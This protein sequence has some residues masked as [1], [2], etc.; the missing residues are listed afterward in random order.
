MRSVF[1]QT[2]ERFTVL[3][4]CHDRP[5]FA[6][7]FDSRLQVMEADFEAPHPGGFC[8]AEG[9]RD[10]WEKLLDGLIATPALAPTYV[11]VRDCDDFI[12]RR[13]VAYCLRADDPNGYSLRTGYLHRTGS[14]WLTY[15]PAFWRN[16]GSS[17]VLRADRLRFPQSKGQAERDACLFMTHGHTV[18]RQAMVDRGWPLADIPFPSGVYS[19]SHGDNVTDTRKTPWAKLLRRSEC[20]DGLRELGLIRPLTRCIREEFSLPEAG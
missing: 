11:M 5:G 18:I 3:L 14:R 20:R 8:A 16:C 19:I 13:L 1:A 12:S 9:N 2:D 7:E 15:T 17:A 4:L 10:K 6:A